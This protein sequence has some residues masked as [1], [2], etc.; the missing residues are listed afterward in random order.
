MDRLLQVR[1]P[2]ASAVRRSMRS[3]FLN[4]Q[5]EQ[6]HLVPSNTPHTRRLLPAPSQAA[7]DRANRAEEQIKR[8]RSEFAM[9]LSQVRFILLLSTR[10]CQYWSHQVSNACLVFPRSSLWSKQTRS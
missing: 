1:Y 5:N 8:E 10:D 6:C 4:R 9:R 7:E 2:L 3:L